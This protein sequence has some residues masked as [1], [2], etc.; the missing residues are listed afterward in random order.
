[1]TT[2]IQMNEPHGRARLS[3]LIAADGQTPK[4]FNDQ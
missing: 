3:L 1:M 4:P 2:V